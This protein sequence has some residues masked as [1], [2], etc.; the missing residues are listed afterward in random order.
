MIPEWVSVRTQLTSPLAIVRASPGAVFRGEFGG[1]YAT[2]D[3]AK[4]HAQP[5]VEHSHWSNPGDLNPGP[6]HYEPFVAPLGTRPYP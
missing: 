5:A 4:H 2:R 6:T 3:E 1:D